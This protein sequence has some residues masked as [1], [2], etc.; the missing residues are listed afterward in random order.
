[1]AVDPIRML[2]L[3]NNW[4]A[5]SACTAECKTL[6]PVGE[7]LWAGNTAWCDLVIAKSPVFGKLLFMDGEIQSA[8]SDEA[9]YHEHLVHPLMNSL[10]NRPNKRV[11]IVGG[12]EG[13]TLRE[14]LKWS[15]V[16]DVVWVDIDEDAVNLCRRHLVYADDDVYN[17]PRVEH[18]WVDI[19]KYLEGPTGSFDAVILDLPDPDVKK[20][21]VNNA[22]LY[23]HAFYLAIMGT[24]LPGGGIV[25]HVGPV[26]PGGDPFERR[27]GLMWV[28]G[29]WQT[30]VGY[31]VYIPSFQ[32]EWGFWMSLSPSDIDKFPKTCLVM[33]NS[34]QSHAFFWPKYWTE[35]AA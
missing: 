12:G 20:L 8:A 22:Y 1:M 10:A 11:L 27:E 3:S 34:T 13:A 26:Q 30:G 2:A 5:E 7:C 25:S 31:H 16:A 32:S 15:S 35:T 33:D 4:F 29:V 14:V 21:R 18:H 23:S 24:L 6:Y 19:C 28:Q 17:D 9:I